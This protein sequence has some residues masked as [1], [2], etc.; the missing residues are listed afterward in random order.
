VNVVDRRTLDGKVALISGAARGQGA[1]EARLFAQRGARVVLGDVLYDDAK[2]VAADI[3]DAAVAMHLDV[4]SAASWRDAVG[5]AVDSFGGLHVLVNNAGIVRTGTVEL[6]TE[7]DFMA[8]V[9]VNQLG[10]L[11][12]MQAAIP[13]L[14]KAAPGSAIVNISST[15]GFEGVGGVI[16]YVATKFAVRGMTKTAAIE[17]GHDGIRVNSVHP[18]TID[19]PMVSS[20]QFDAVDKDAVFGALPIPRIGQPDEVAELVAWLA[21]DAASYCTGAEFVVDGGA[22][23]GGPFDIT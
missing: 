6:V 15:A 1:A 9:K 3:G 23:A 21:S 8:V 18:G 7:A 22:L 10:C 16:S 2:A 17:L 13:E 5:A 11:L 19:T 4:T 20:A 14:R 12:G